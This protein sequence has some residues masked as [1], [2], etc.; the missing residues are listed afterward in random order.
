MVAWYV[1]SNVS[2]MNLICAASQR[3]ILQRSLRRATRTHR[4]IRLVFPTDW[5]PNNTIFV[6]FRGDEEKSA[7]AGVCGVAMLVARPQ[8]LL[9][10]DIRYSSFVTPCVTQLKVS[11][12]AE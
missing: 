1:L 12:V 9:M 7:E 11:R 10:F 4:V 5:S 6:R 8:L 3:N 2:Y